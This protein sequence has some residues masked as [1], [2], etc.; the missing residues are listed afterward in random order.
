V[1]SPLAHRL[2]KLHAGGGGAGAITAAGARLLA[3][4]PAL[5]NLRVLK[6]DNAN[7]G[8]AGARHLAKSPHLSGLTEL[9]LHMCEIRNAGV[10]AIAASPN[11]ANLEV[12]DLTSNW[13]VGHAA[14]VALVESPFL[15]KIRSLDLWR[16]EGMS[17]ADEQMLRKRFRSRVNFAR[18]Y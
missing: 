13:T 2:R 1:E 4:T 14:A 10:Q 7:L 8:D 3:H 17:R 11:L 15:K 12:L 6:L 18:S 9:W 16:C 5:A